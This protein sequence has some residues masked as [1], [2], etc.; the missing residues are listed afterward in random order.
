[1]PRQHWPAPERNKIPIADVLSRFLPEN[2][3]VLELSSGTGQHIL[4]FAARFPG[5][6]WIPSDI[7]PANLES[8]HAY[9]SEA[10]LPNLQAPCS[11]DVTRPHWPVPKVQ[12]VFCAN[13]IHIAPFSCTLGLLDGVARVLLPGG[14][15]FLYGPFMVDGQH[16]APSNQ[17]FDADLRQRNP[18]WGVRDQGEVIRLAAERGLNLQ[19]IVELPANNRILVL[20]R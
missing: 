17:A 4:Y 20:G 1:M 2:G 13:M 16:T 3:T 10:G 19:E 11:L 7:N 5:L 12:A 6:C 8:I 18:A 14:F 15:F 9:R